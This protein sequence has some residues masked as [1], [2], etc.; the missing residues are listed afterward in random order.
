[1]NNRTYIAVLTAFII[2]LTDISHQRNG[3]WEDDIRLWEDAA[4]G[5]PAR[6]RTMYNLGNAYA[7]T[8]DFTDALAM[9]NKAVELDPSSAATY[10]KRAN[11]YDDL[12]LP[13]QSMQD[14]RR[15]IAMA[16]L[17]PDVYYDLGLAY[18]R[19]GELTEAAEKYDT[20]CALGDRRSCGA[21]ESLAPR[22]R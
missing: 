12:G 21:R 11:T 19:R 14:Y 10:H 20:G 1:M 7:K 2:L 9:F 13:E 18:E 17:Y 15:V 22:M 8:G 5:S 16:P 4:A 3:I 6:H